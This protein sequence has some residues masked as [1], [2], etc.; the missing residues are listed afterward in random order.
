MGVDT[1]VDLDKLMAARGAL[2]QGL[3]DEPLYGMV[4]DAGLPANFIPHVR[5]LRKPA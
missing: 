2:Q 4:P 1:G 3:P 5:P